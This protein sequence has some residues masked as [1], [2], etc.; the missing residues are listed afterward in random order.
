MLTLDAPHH[1]GPRVCSTCMPSVQAYVNTL[2]A[3]LE[4]AE[5]EECHRK[6][7]ARPGW[8]SVRGRPQVRVRRKR[9]K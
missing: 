4:I 1:D 2:G 9:Q 6:L 3:L 7:M 8:L 5:N